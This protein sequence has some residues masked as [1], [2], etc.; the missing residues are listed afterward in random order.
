MSGHDFI[1]CNTT[2]RMPILSFL[3]PVPDPGPT[4]RLAGGAT[5]Y[6]GRVEV[7]Y[8]GTWGAVGHTYCDINDNIGRVAR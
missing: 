7:G 3:A 4:L 8:G 6:E 2:V 1:L 5:P